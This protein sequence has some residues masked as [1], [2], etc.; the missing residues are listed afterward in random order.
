[1]FLNK[2]V[3][4][5]RVNNWKTL[6]IKDA[7]FSGY[8][9]Y[10]NTKMQG[11]FQICISV[12]LR[13]QSKGTSRQFL[14]PVVQRTVNRFKEMKG[15]DE[16]FLKAHVVVRFLAEQKIRMRRRQ[17]NKNLPKENK[18]SDLKKQHATYR[19]SC[20]RFGTDETYDSKRGRFKPTQAESESRPST[21]RKHLN[22]LSQDQKTITPGSTPGPYLCYIFPTFSLL[23][24]VYQ[25]IQVEQVEALIVAPYW[26]TQPWFSQILNLVA[27]EPL[28]YKPTAANL[29]L[30]QDPIAKHRL[31]EKLSFMVSVL[32]GKNIRNQGT[33]KTQETFYWQ[34][35]DQVH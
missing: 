25:K 27:Q 22:T 7:E 4:T 11:D 21:I 18:E 32:S 16:I 1:M 12:P 5:L 9:F 31:A 6:R 28:I 24:P 20:I 10:M 33:L 3:E 2:H 29:I 35:G 8:Y 15:G 23:P 30:P 14:L 26:P 19:E 17:R 34:A 13:S